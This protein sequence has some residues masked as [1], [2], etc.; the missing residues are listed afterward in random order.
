MLLVFI[1]RL[2]YTDW[3]K[4]VH[5]DK[6]VFALDLPSNKLNA[7][8]ASL[9][10]YLVRLIVSL[11]KWLEVRWS[12][13]NKLHSQPDNKNATRTKRLSLSS[14]LVRFASVAISALSTTSGQH[15]IAT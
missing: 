14:V 11:T 7:K 15:Y 4:L 10:C 5:G 13:N 6:F 12:R 9:K 2:Y 3:G 1:A 8:G